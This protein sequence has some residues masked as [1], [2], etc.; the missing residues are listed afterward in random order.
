MKVFR[1]GKE[2]KDVRV[3]FDTAGNPFKIYDKHNIRQ[4]IEE[5]TFGD[6]EPK[7][8]TTGAKVD[9]AKE[10][11]AGQTKKRKGLLGRLKK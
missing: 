10:P 4:P 8:R 6:S 2:V 11:K 7:K 9:P 5:F 1:N 3:V